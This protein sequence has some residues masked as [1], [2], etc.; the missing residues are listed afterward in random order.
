MPETLIATSG[1][2][3]SQ[4]I[5]RLKAEDPGCRIGV[6][7]IGGGGYRITVEPSPDRDGEQPDGVAENPVAPERLD[8]HDSAW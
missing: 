4:I 6:E 5:T 8:T 3:L 7:E 2:H 1:A